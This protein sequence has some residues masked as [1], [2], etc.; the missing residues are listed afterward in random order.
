MTNK[1]NHNNCQLSK[2]DLN[3]RQFL[4]NA[5]LAASGFALSSCGW[6]LAEVRTTDPERDTSNTLRIYTYAG[7]TDQ[8][9]F[10]SF[11]T[12]TGVKVIA[13]VYDSNEVMLAKMQAG[14][15]TGYSIIYPSDY[16]VRQMIELGMLSQLDRN[17]INGIENLLPQFQNPSYDPGNLHSIPVS[18]GTT[19]LIYNSEKL[20]NPP[21]DW[22][23]IWQNQ[24]LLSRRITMINDAREVLGATLRM[25]G[26][27]YNS[28]KVEQLQQAYQKLQQLKPALAAFTTDA[29]KEQILA[30][31]LLIAMGYSP[32]A[33]EVTEENPSLKY[34][35]PRSGTS[36]WTDTM[37][38][39][40]TAP[41]PDAAYAWLNF[42]LQP[43]VAASVC[44][45]LNFA[46]PNQPAI[47]QL[48]PKAQKN[49]SLYPPENVLSK[50][51]RIE[52][53]DKF[54]EFYERYWT[55]LT[56]S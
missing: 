6:T 16:M 36:L 25:L 29:W 52:P 9:L 15:G 28:T 23:Y 22:D 26:Y 47:K 46:T 55:Q 38:I 21:E 27:S 10:N 33:V 49:T 8:E 1:V 34:I 31:D 44:G 24:Q 35:I 51:E 13:D 4:K 48:S 2:I 50:C 42:M 30:G 14:G 18:W 45:R 54:G 41:N 3:R 17:R 12:N 39:P 32:D 20:K 40:K 43:T 37:V 19:G 11:T 56:S 5:A 7:Y 53:L